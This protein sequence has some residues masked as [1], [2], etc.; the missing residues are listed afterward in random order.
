MASAN[1]RLAAATAAGAGFT[2]LA[3]LSFLIILASLAVFPES[4]YLW[5]AYL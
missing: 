3:A 5:T 4:F 2:P 1:A